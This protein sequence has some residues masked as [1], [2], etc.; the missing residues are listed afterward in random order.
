MAKTRT[1][2]AAAPTTDAQLDDS[3]EHEA[4]TPLMRRLA[5]EYW[6]IVRARAAD[7]GLPIVGAWLW[8]RIDMENVPHVHLVVHFDVPDEQALAFHRGLNDECYRWEMQLDPE[9]YEVVLRLSLMP[10]GI[11]R[12]GKSANGA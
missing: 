9:A 4:L 6:D 2:T 11:R 7:Q 12:G 3:A 5:G 10:V 8:P 1:R